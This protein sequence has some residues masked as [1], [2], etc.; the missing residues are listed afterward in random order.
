M[1]A[2][3]LPHLDEIGD[4]CRRANEDLCASRQVYPAEALGVAQAALCILI[5][6]VSAHVRLLKLEVEIEQRAKA[7]KAAA[8]PMLR[9]P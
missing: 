9:Q 7:W 8:G 2:H 3:L 4:A 5:A 6:S 1:T